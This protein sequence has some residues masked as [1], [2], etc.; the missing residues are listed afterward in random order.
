MDEPLS[1]PAVAVRVVLASGSP[2]RLELLRR[3]GI[4]PDVRPADVD[5]TA[6]P[7][8]APVALVT[9]LARAKAGAVAVGDDALVVAADTVVVLGEE[10]LGKPTDHSDAVAMLRRLSGATHHVLTGVHV[11]HAGRE[12]SAVE[13]TM[14]RFRGLSPHEIAAYV[15]TGEPLDKAG[16]YAIQGGAGMF[17]TGIEGSDTN[18]VG[19]PLATVVRLANEV[20]VALL[21]R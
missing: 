9:R 18:V 20:G 8:E 15:A 12:A 1:E 3:L 13:T 16:A 6:A 2:R 10:V 4:E 11:A 19:L 5:E 7:G 14:V 21:P 17:V